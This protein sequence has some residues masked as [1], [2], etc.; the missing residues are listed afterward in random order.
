[1]VVMSTAGNFQT[2]RSDADL[3]RS[4]VLREW[5][6]VGK[7]FN[8]IVGSEVAL[9]KYEKPPFFLSFKFFWGVKQ[10]A[11]MMNQG[12]VK[13]TSESVEKVLAAYFCHY[14]I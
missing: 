10:Q 7:F 14:R 3:L 11:F 2:I 9:C 6:G 8:F 5:N 13:I 1:M 12:K 4:T